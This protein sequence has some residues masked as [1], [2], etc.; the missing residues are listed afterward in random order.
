MLRLNDI[1]TYY[2]E[3]HI[4]HGVSLEVEKGSVVALL[5]RNGMG[6]T[7]TVRSI[8]GMTPARQGTIHFNGKEIT[9]LA[10]YQIARMGLALI[11]QGRRIF[12]SLS[13]YENLLLG[14]RG[15]GYSLDMAYSD[16]PIL[17]VR[18]HL[19][20]NLLSGG[21]QQML[22]IVRAML[23]NPELILMDEASEGLAPVIIE[24]IGDYILLHSGY[25]IQKIDAREAEETLALLK[26]AAEKLAAEQ[27]G[28]T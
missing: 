3:S 5:G 10:A 7:T 15:D 21:E 16:F 23:S 27:S 12:P 9:R 11:P 6:K 18:G 13:V 2:G 24:Q 20:G 14:M 25:A 28:D 19:K 8:M 22:A 4:L 26:E 17:K 1:H